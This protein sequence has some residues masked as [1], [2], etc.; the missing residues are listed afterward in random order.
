MFVEWTSNT[1]DNKNRNLP[2]LMAALLDAGNPVTGTV[3]FHLEK[4]YRFEF[5]GTWVVINENGVPLLACQWVNGEWSIS[6]EIQSWS[7]GSS[8]SDGETDTLN[9]TSIQPKTI[10]INTTNTV[11][12]IRYIPAA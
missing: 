11:Y 7:W 5:N 10:I 3:K 1:P 9:V 8:D 2:D 6:S 12:R 4:P